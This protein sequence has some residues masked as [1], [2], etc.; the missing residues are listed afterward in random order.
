MIINIGDIYESNMCGKFEV[1][2]KLIILGLSPGERVKEP[3]Y[4]VQFVDTGFVCEASRSA[5]MSGRIKDRYLP[6][7]CG[8]GYVGNIKKIIDPQIF[9]YYK[10]WNDMMHRCYNPQDADY[11]LYGA[12]GVTVDPRWFCFENYLWDVKFL[13][14]HEKKIMYPNEYQLDKDYLQLHIPKSQRVYSKETCMWI[15]KYDNIMIMNRDTPTSSGYYGV[16]YIY[17]SYYAHINGIKIGRY[18]N[19]TAA[20]NRFN[21]EYLKLPRHPFNDIQ[22]LNDV[23]YMSPEEVEMYAVKKGICMR[24]YV[25]P[26]TIPEM[27]V[28]SK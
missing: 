2:K 17:G 4:L 21:H 28:E 9:M 10:S 26:T 1:L 7:V 25:G 5:I 12:I 13:P 27:G 15:S 8:V 24:N 16:R 18:S 14:N 6:S 23:P 3:Y 19:A 20:A 11:Y 22:I